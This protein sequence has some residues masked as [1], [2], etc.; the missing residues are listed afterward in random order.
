MKKVAH[1][2]FTFGVI[3]NPNKPNED[4]GA[5]VLRN[6]FKDKD[7]RSFMAGVF[8]GLNAPNTKSQ[9]VVRVG[10]K[11]V[12]GMNAAGKPFTWWVEDSKKE[13][14]IFV[15]GKAE[16]AD[17]I[18]ETVDGKRPN[19]L[20][21]P[22]RV[23]LLKTENTF[24]PTGLAFIDPRVFE[25][26]RTTPG[27]KN[28]EKDYGYLG[29]GNINSVDIRWGFQDEALMTLTRIATKGPRKGLLAFLDSSTLDKA[30]LP[31]IP[32]SVSGF[33]VASFDLAGSLDRLRT[34]MK[35][36]SPEAD[37]AVDKFVEK[38]K[39]KTKLRLKEDILAHIGPKIAWYSLPGKGGSAPKPVASGML[40]G[41]E[42]PR[43]ALVL[44]I[45]DP[46]AFGK[47]L[48]QVIAAANREFKSMGQ[49]AGEAPTK[50]AR[51]RGPSL[52]APEF[53]I[54]PGETK[55]YVLNVPQEMA[56]Q[57]P[58]WFRPAIRVGPK[59][60]VLA[61][62]T[63]I[64]KAVLDSKETWTPPDNLSVAFQGLPS[65]LKILNV[66]DPR[67]VL[68][69]LL[70]ALPGKIQ[71]IAALAAMGRAKMPQ[72]AGGPPA[73][74]SGPPPGG[75]PPLVLRID[76][77]KL[78]SADA[79]KSLLFP[80]LFTVETTSDE[81]RIASRDAFPTIGDPSTMAVQMAL[82]LPAIQAARDAA[83]RAQQPGAAPP[84]GGP[85]SGGSPPVPKSGATKNP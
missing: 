70:A 20:D 85:P 60:A 61:V 36:L 1:Y 34:E 55:G 46:T 53:R 58:A 45:D 76:A 25:R 44:D 32:P 41:M 42:N 59:H 30:K 8:S 83:R 68:P 73:P 18:L 28:F 26:M 24:L 77:A 33:T 63:D 69:S 12:T 67:E 29:I 65:N 6:A 64:A 84:P 13:D 81:L 5:I 54:A 79:I 80:S 51:A 19:V 82:I 9:S 62:S 31:P 11:V 43:L 56:S 16:D 40:A 39:E 22:K 17:Q 57:F 27:G 15:F 10:H 37:G 35:M 48:D 2:G 50:G 72:P 38:V 4:F 3:D 23:E 74:P 75:P 52:P 71:Q 66:T 78:P 49:P 14:I 21:H 7:L 47:V